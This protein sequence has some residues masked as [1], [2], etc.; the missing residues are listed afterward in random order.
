[1]TTKRAIPSIALLLFAL[2]LIPAAAVAANLAVDPGFEANG[3]NP[4]DPPSYAWKPYLRTGLPS[5]TWGGPGSGDYAQIVPSKTIIDPLAPNPILPHSGQYLLDL[6]LETN[7]AWAGV[8][9][10]VTGLDPGTTYTVGLWAR[11]K[12]DLEEYGIWYGLLRYDTAG[13]T[14]PAVAT[15]FPPSATPPYPLVPDTTYTHQQWYRYSVEITGTDRV[16]LFAELQA[17]PARAEYG[18]NL[19]IDDVY[20]G[21]ATPA[22][23]YVTNVTVANT[24]TDSV[25]IEW[26]T[27]DA[28]GAPLAMSSHVDYGLTTGYG[29]AFDDPTPAS[30][31]IADL[32]GLACPETYHALITS[33]A[34]GYLDATYGDFTFGSGLP[35]VIS[36]VTATPGVNS[37][38]IEWD[39]DVAA[40]SR[41]DYDLHSGSY[42]HTRYT[43]SQVTHHSVSLTDLYSNSRY[44]FQITSGSIQP[45]RLPAETAEASFITSSASNLLVN[46]SFETGTDGVYGWQPWLGL[47]PPDSGQVIA[48]WNGIAAYAGSK[49]LGFTESGVMTYEGAGALQ[50]VG[51]TVAG[52]TYVA[53]ARVLTRAGDPGT[54]LDQYVSARIGIDP[55]GGCVNPST[56][57]ADPRNPNIVWS[58]WTS[59]QDAWQFICTPPVTAQTATIT[60]YLQTDHLLPLATNLVAFDGCVLDGPRTAPVPMSNDFAAN[61]HMIAFPNQPANGDP[62]QLLDELRPPTQTL[63]LLTGALHRYDPYAQGY[64]TYTHSS[65]TPFGVIQPGAGYWLYLPEATTISY[66]THRL[67][68]PYCIS[69]PKAG[70]YLIGDPFDGPVPLADCW[71]IRPANDATIESKTMPEA[72]NVWIQIPFVYYDNAASSYRYLGLSGYDDTQLRPWTAYWVN[73]FVGNLQLVIPPPS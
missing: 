64:N 14:D 48:P 40:D 19:M 24:A 38:V 2:C 39:T 36:N 9:Q 49:F 6:H 70:W 53:S 46:G 47:W 22:P 68:E 35:V 34:A 30:H 10:T 20:I 72:A 73:T 26:D 29:D 32:T 1:V 63:D 61:W 55:T 42:D 57:P 37:A 54:Y 59:S 66:D 11:A 51:G 3:G 28:D 69:M 56:L 16:T 18:L 58:N 15:S 50:Q 25:R 5:F 13:G 17:G 27:S 62:W 71:L 31:H 52:E 33:T 12:G 65:P 60:V 4:P 41:V 67:V 23:A 45:C 7:L 44:Y 43:S 8:Y 21:P